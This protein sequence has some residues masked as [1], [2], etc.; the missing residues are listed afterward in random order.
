[1]AIGSAP[2]F[3]F[4]GLQRYIDDSS[5]N[6]NQGKKPG[7][8]SKNLQ[9]AITHSPETMAF[10]SVAIDRNCWISELPENVP[11]GFLFYFFGV[12]IRNKQKIRGKSSDKTTEGNKA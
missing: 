1:M 4:F 9:R 2:W 5:Y 6:H 12:E 10:F 3:S 11:P 7:A 8:N